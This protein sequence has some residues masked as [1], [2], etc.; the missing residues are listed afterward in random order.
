MAFGIYGV[1]MTVDW[2]NKRPPLVVDT[3]LLGNGKAL[4]AAPDGD[5]LNARMLVAADGFH[6]KPTDF[7]DLSLPKLSFASQVGKLF[8][9]SF[10]DQGELLINGNK[11]VAPTN[12]EDEFIEGNKTFEGMTELKG[13]AKLL[14][15][16]G[17]KFSLTVDDD[18]KLTA[19]K[20][21]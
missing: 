7:D 1:D 5:K 14:S 20:E 11:Y 4:Y 13:G 12:Q 3:S 10:D 21:E 16:S 2:N 6:F 17:T 15:P 18:G 9:I 8:A 19:V